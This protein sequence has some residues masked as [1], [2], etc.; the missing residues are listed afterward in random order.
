M[1]SSTP[2]SLHEPASR[3]YAAPHVAHCHAVHALHTPSQH[4]G[5]LHSRT[6]PTSGQQYIARQPGH[7]TSGEHDE[8]LRTPQWTQRSSGHVV[9]SPHVSH[10]PTSMAI[11]RPSEARARTSDAT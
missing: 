9:A 6:P 3:Q 1:H 8:Q 7:D 2:H 11:S 5:R 10:T 4:A